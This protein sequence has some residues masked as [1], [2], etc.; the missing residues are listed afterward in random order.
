MT[1]EVKLFLKIDDVEYGPLTVAEVK[2]WIDQGKFRR[3]DY[4]RMADKKTWVK[5]ENLVHLKA[6]F[7]EAKKKVSRGAFEAWLESVRTGKPAMVLSTAGRVAEQ[8]RIDAEQAALAEERARL[9]AEERALREKLAAEVARREEEL[10]RLQAEREAER[11]RLEAERDEEVRRLAA[12]REAERQRLEAERAA[13]VARLK[14]E[15]ERELSRFAEE[16]RRL[17]AE[18]ARLEEEEREL[19]AMGKAVRRRRRLPLVV[20]AVIVGLAIIGGVPS[21]YWLV[22][23][24]SKEAEAR[25]AR[26]AD[27]EQRIA[28]LTAQLEKALK[29][30]DV[31]KAQEITKEIEKVKAEKEKLVKEKGG[32]EPKMPTSRGRAK[33]AGLLRAEGP[34][35]SDP[36][37]GDGAI[38]AG[39]AAGMAGVRVTYSRELA[40]NPGLAG[41]VVVGIKVAADGTVTNAWVISSTIGNSAV[42]NA[43]TA[44]ARSA[45]FAPATGE[46]SLTYKFEFSP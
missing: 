37:R 9:E 18:R 23:K 2:E 43:V 44:A 41:H 32:E 3:T 31:A 33:L 28:D 38:A 40:K 12:E 15:Q 22:Y 4:I 35:A 45:R 6:L 11:R 24:P 36:S 26:I 8:R 13:E 19:R 42:E 10:A 30:G 34:G 46:S 20:A 14:A 5:A 7:D 29:A 1:D 39:L 16:R 25:L 21:W 27:L 17:E